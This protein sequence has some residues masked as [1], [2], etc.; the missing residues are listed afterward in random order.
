MRGFTDD[1]VSIAKNCK[2]DHP[3]QRVGSMDNY[4]KREVD[5]KLSKSPNKKLQLMMSDE[6]LITF[7]LFGQ[8]EEMVKLAEATMEHCHELNHPKGEEL[9]LFLM[10]NETLYT[11]EDRKRIEDYAQNYIWY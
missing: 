8:G 6:K 4:K 7:Y 1:V 5:Q 2:G 10:K 11:G 9:R 3:I